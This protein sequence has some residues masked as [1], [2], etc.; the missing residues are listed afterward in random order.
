MLKIPQL[1]ISILSFFK[2]RI[3]FLLLDS[4]PELMRGSFINIYTKVNL[5]TVL[6]G[7]QMGL[8][9]SSRA[10]YK[11]LSHTAIDGDRLG[12]IYS[13]CPIWH[14]LWKYPS[15]NVTSLCAR[16]IY[17]NPPPISLSGSRKLQ[18]WNGTKAY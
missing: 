15:N 9:V 11:S 17:S 10:L 13:L 2:V 18:K 6:I 12:N 4:I 14:L 16:L 1:Y 8:R 3:L 7:L 5:K